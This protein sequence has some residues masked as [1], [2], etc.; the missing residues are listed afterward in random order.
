MYKRRAQSPHL[1]RQN[2]GTKGLEGAF[3]WIAVPFFHPTEILQF[4]EPEAFLY[5]LFVA[6]VQ[7]FV[8]TPATVLSLFSFVSFE[9]R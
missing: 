6:F 9:E 2:A 1:R 3:S 7:P 8:G 5:S 4:V